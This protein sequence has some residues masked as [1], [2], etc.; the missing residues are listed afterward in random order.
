MYSD[1]SHMASSSAIVVMSFVML[2]FIAPLLL[3]QRT[4]LRARFVIGVML[5]TGICGICSIER[6][7]ESV[8]L[9][10]GERRCAPSTIERREPLCGETTTRALVRR[11]QAM[12]TVVPCVQASDERRNYTIYEPLCRE[13]KPC[14]SLCGWTST[15]TFVQRVS[16]CISLT[17]N[18]KELVCPRVDPL[19]EIF[20]SK[21][22]ALDKWAEIQT[23]ASDWPMRVQLEW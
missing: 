1:R 9:C 11:G 4:W 12:C 8:H 3:L 7:S 18:K 17:S 19:I 16:D 10:M 22:N 14:A 15:C 21:D 6:A 5:T 20:G 23:T 2:A 13:N